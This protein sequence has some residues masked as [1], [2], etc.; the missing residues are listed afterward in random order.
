MR[1]HSNG[2]VDVIW[3]QICTEPARSKS[4][5]DALAGS[6]RGP[7][8]APSVS[9][10]F[11]PVIANGRISS[12]GWYW[13]VSEEVTSVKTGLAIETAIDEYP[14]LIARLNVECDDDQLQV[15][16]WWHIQ[17][18]FAASVLVRFGSEDFLRQTW[19]RG[20]GTWGIDGVT[21]DW[22]RAISQ[23]QEAFARELAWAAAAGDSFTMQI[24]SGRDTYTATFNLDGL[25][26]TPV[27]PNLARC[28]R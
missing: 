19:R 27:Q 11:Q 26:D 28:G 7:E 6:M 2:G 3:S 4:Y 20:T 22:H 23:S 10:E 5:C 13:T 9:G 21:V 17:R 14:D 16:V 8:Q 24:R 1:A 25:F 15:E 12:H 18:G